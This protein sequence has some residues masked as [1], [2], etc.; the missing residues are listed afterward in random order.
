MTTHPLLPISVTEHP[1][2]RV[3]VRP[4]SY[5]RELVPRLRDLFKILEQTKLQL[6]GWDYPHISHCLEERNQGQNWIASWCTFR[7]HEEYLRFH[8]SGQ[9]L[10]LFR[11][12]ESS[13]EWKAE[14]EESTKS[15]LVKDDIDWSKVHG[16]FSIFNFL[17]TVTEIFEFAARLCQ[18]GLYKESVSISIDLKQI[19][20][21]MLTTDWGRARLDYSI[22]DSDI[23]SKSWEIEAKDL[24]SGSANHSLKAA[25]WFFEQFGWMTLNEQVL[26]QDQ[27]NFLQGLH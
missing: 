19:K 16:Y 3:I 24:L 11:V 26:R 9:F 22:C 2:W 4:M 14:L 23:L 8:Q 1:H 5:S 15:N 20:G 10:H 18:K 6:R 7:T 12:R 27:Q 13:L 17:Y 21:F 25:I